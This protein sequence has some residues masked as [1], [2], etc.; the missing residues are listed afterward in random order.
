MSSEQKTVHS[1]ELNPSTAAPVGPSLRPMVTEEFAT[2]SAVLCNILVTELVSQILGTV[3]HVTET[4]MKNIIAKLTVILMSEIAGYTITNSHDITKVARE[5]HKELCTNV[6]NNKD[7]RAMLLLG[8]THFYK[9]ITVT[10][11]RR[12]LTSEKKSDMKRFF[13]TF[14]NFVAK[15][16]WAYLFC[17][18]VLPED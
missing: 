6:G 5:V 4:K 16:G 11:M 18:T 10:L 13:S 8:E 1:Q 7:I 12:L 14:L 17:C 2:E 9:Y 15:A 3:S